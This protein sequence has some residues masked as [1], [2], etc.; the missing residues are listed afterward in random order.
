[1]ITDI[2]EAVDRWGINEPNRPVYIEADQT[3][4]YGELKR[5]S[6][7]V[8]GYLQQN[9]ERSR[10]V[11]VYG[12][13]E[14]DMLAC[15]LGASKAGHAYIPIEAHTP[16]ERIEMILDVAEPAL[17]F[18]IADWPDIATQAEIISLEKVKEEHTISTSADTLRPVEGSQTYYIIFTSGTTG[19]PKGVQ[20]SHTNLLSFVNWEL[21][22]FGISEG[23]R[24]LSQA[25]YSF[26]LSVMDLYPAL[27]SGGSL[28]PMKKE[29][30]TDFKQL[31]KVLPTL[32]IEVW[33][34]TPSFMDIC[35]MEPNF[36]QKN[37]KSLKIFLF[38]GEELP[39]ATAQKLLERFPDAHIF[40]TYGP[41]EATVAISGVEITPELLEKYDRIPIGYVKEDT[42][43]YIMDE[44][45]ELPEG[46]VGEIIIAGPSVSKGYMNNKEK[47]EAAFFEYQGQPAYRTG[48]AGKLEE[49]MLIYDGRIDFQ[50][51]M[52]GYRIELEDIDHHLANVSYV[53]QAAVVPKYH[54]HKV[55]QL[56]AFVVAH[57]NEFEKE[58]KL[59]KAIKEELG[60][61]VMDY[62]IPQKFVYVEQL[63]LTPNGKIDRKGLMNEVNVT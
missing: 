31:F 61:T 23:M 18:S 9:I 32:E 15:F 14:F 12:E 22:D 33:V 50:I 13:L 42:H 35:L 45:T 55:Q 30:I 24:F 43:V 17:I 29:I 5:D 51:K 37:V 57:P 7:A 8:A 3:Y 56:V 28:T 27:V 38:C 44:N 21:A 62:M 46:E 54:E 36:E 6:D 60:Q 10:P 47:T 25:P 1:M 11:V 40:N 19:V 39:K 16:A 48:D 26:D 58:F 34:S 59:T 41:T 53:K 20:I 49:S 4:T 2:I 63:P 52:H